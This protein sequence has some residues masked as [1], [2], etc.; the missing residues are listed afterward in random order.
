M[1]VSKTWTKNSQ[2]NA[3]GNAL[4]ALAKLSQPEVSVMRGGEVV[5]IP[6]VPGT[7]TCSIFCWYNGTTEVLLVKSLFRMVKN[8]EKSQL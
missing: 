5:S 6:T 1:F 7:A 3:A 4:D 2:E 8:H